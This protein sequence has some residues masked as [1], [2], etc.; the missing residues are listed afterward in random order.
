MHLNLAGI[1]HQTAPLA[2]RERAAINSGRLND[3][4]LLLRS[5]IPQGVILST[6]NRTEIYTVNASNEE[7]N[8]KTG[9]DFLKVMLEVPDDQLPN[10]IY[11]HRDT[12]AAM[13]LFRVTSGLES[14][15]VGEYEVLGQVRQALEAAEKMGTVNL[16]LR[17][18][19]QSAI[20]TGRLVRE[21]TGISRNALS[22]SSAAV[23]LAADIVGDMKKCIMLIIGA[24]EAGRLVA[25]VAV[26]RGV[27][28]IVIASR[29][30]ERA[31]SLASILN[32]MPTDL[33]DLDRELTTTNIVVTCA[34]AP[35]RIL[36]FDRVEAVMKKR[37]YLPL[38]IIDIAIPRNVEPE[39][40]NIKGVFLYNI[41]DLTG[42]AKRNRKQR[43]NEI[44]R[45]EQIITDE[46]SKFDSWWHDLEIRPLVGALMSRAEEIRLAQLNKTLKRLPPLSDEQR[47]NLEAMT[48]SII[49][50][51]LKEPVQYLKTNG[52]SR[53]TEFV[54]QLFNLKAE[55][56]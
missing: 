11:T 20:R 52:N 40:S 49:T 41:D 30:K 6:C 25:Q 17:H 34:D 22:V 55:K 15:V 2:I 29:T 47:Q 1:N 26:K 31:Q 35:H 10:Y 39:V 44:Q 27:S 36:G 4:L 5:H 54:K 12:E 33:H 24:G 38:V 13:H 42:I 3:S 21:Q 51:I 46:V 19:F 53:Q 28:Q 45:A 32:G 43:E 14:M 23:D 9:L 16:P 48:K 7:T 18:T 56:F 8:A 50:K 37:P